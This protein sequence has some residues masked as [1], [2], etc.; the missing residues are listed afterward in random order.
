MDSNEVAIIVNLTPS[1]ARPGR[2]NK[3]TD[4]NSAYYR[5]SA[6]DLLCELRPVF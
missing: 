2:I 1:S 6:R 5:F 3:D 4:S